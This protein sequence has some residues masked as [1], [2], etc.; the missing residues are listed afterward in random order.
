MSGPPS[1]ASA[2][3]WPNTSAQ[4]WFASMRMPS[5]T[6]AIASTEPAMKSLSW[7]LYWLADTKLSLSAR[8]SRNARS[9]RSATLRSRSVWPRDTRSWAPASSASAMS[10]S[11]AALLTTTSGTMR[12]ACCLIFAISRMGAGRL[13][14][15]KQRS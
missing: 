7:R 10:V 15:K 11:S 3:A 6:C 12:A 14:G 8:S 1:N 4:A 13:S 5:L 2:L 9:S